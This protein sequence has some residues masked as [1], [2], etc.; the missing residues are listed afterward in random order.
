M[1]SSPPPKSLI[2]SFFLLLLLLSWGAP[3]DATPRITSITPSCAVPSDQTLL[4][5]TGFG[6]QNVTV[7]VNGVP[8]TVVSATGARV[9]F[10]V[11]T[12]VPSGIAV[13][14][15]ANPGQ[16]GGT[17]A[18]RI[19][20]PEVCGNTIDEDCDGQLNDPDVCTPVNH[21]PTAHAGPDQTVPVGSLVTLD[22]SGSSDPDGNPLSFQ[23]T[24]SARPNE[25]LTSLTNATTVA[26]SFTVDTTGTYHIQLQV[27]DGHLSSTTDLVIVSTLNSAPVADAGSDQ[28]GQVGNTLLLTGAGSTDIDGDPLT[29]QWSLLAAPAES[30]ALLVSPTSVTPS[31][32]NHK[33]INYRICVAGRGKIS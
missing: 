29:Y 21:A 27:S 30:T 10:V 3:A 13:V 5:G 7:T 14:K 33:T 12:G 8:A 17:I 11:P 31:L 23:W 16:Q 15:A 20:G 28:T 26:P 4:T 9:T 19:K 25:S 6:A 22:G 32:R 18:L 1:E 24:L 2:V